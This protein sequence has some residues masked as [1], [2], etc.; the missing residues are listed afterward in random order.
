MHARSNPGLGQDAEA[1][2]KPMFSLYEKQTDITVHKINNS[3]T[4]MG[5]RIRNR[6]FHSSFHFAE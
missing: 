3:K 5:K 6:E 2:S 4:V 1:L